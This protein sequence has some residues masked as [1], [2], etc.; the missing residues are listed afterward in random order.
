MI[1][2]SPRIPTSRTWT[3][4]QNRGGHCVRTAERSGRLMRDG[5][6][7]KRVMIRSFRGFMIRSFRGFLRVCACSVWAHV[8]YVCR[9]DRCKHFSLS[10]V[11]RTLSYTRVLRSV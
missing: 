1:W 7:A 11:Q 10:G 5:E 6:I 9:V 4:A 3:P 8:R 2:S